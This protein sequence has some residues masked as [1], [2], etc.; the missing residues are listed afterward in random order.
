VTHRLQTRLTASLLGT[1][2]T[3]AAAHA[4]PARPDLPRVLIIGDS[5]SI[6]YTPYVATRLADVARVERIPENGT[7]TAYGLE[8]LAQW[9]G[10]TRW[11]VI[12]FNWGLHDLKVQSDGTRLVSPE[13]Y[14]TNLR[15]LTRRLQATGATLIFA[16]TTP[17][18]DAIERLKVRR[19]AADIPRYNEIARRVMAELNV[20]IDDLYGFVAP[21]VGNLQLPDDPH[22][23]EAGYEALADEVARSIRTRIPGRGPEDDTAPT[24]GSSR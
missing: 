18:P 20:P 11:A 1:L 10:T 9:L 16:T 23:R 3:A 21:R 14:E 15:V 8:H 13:A 12:H 22:F 4:Q 24:G 2:I 19:V 7:S 5:I 17:V 6:G